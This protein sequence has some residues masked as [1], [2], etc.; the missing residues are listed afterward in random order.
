MESW[1]TIM[2]WSKWDPM[3]DDHVRNAVTLIYRAQRPQALAYEHLVCE[4]LDV[5]ARHS[6]I[7]GIISDCSLEA[8]LP[9]TLSLKSLHA[10]YPA[11][12]CV[13]LSSLCKMPKCFI[14]PRR[15]GL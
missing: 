3:R 2:G 10:S 6:E 13:I 5:S 15:P 1:I 8:S 12:K 11:D 4:E 9:H 7:W 14:T